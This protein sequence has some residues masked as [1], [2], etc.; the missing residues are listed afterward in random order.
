MI[1]YVLREY[2]DVFIIAYLD[3][4]FIYLKIFKNYK[5]HVYKVL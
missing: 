1:N 3:N 4:I 5:K 2:L